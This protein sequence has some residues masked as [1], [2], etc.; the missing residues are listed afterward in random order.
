MPP[1]ATAKS[2]PG[3][4]PLQDCSIAIAGTHAGFSAGALEKDFIIPLGATLS[5]TV[6]STTTHLVTTEADYGKP[7]AKVKTAESHDIGIVPLEWLQECLSQN[8]RL[9]E[10]DYSFSKRDS[11]AK[12]SCGE[13]TLSIFPISI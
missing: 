12:V 4:L 3:R 11:T 8:K 13:M 2:A 1:K 9:N 7:S 10:D 5:K 6:I